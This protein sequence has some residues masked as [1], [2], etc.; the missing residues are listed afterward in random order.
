MKPRRKRKQKQSRNTQPKAIGAAAGNISK[1]SQ[2]LG[3]NLTYDLEVQRDDREI[4]AIISDAEYWGKLLKDTPVEKLDPVVLESLRRSYLHI[5][6]MV[7]GAIAE[8]DCQFLN[9]LAAAVQHDIA[10]QKHK[11]AAAVLQYCTL[12]GCGTDDHPCDPTV[13]EQYLAV[14]GITYD[15]AYDNQVP[16][17]LRKFCQKI[18]VVLLKSPVGRPPKTRNQ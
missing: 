8:A 5:G 3:Q 18:G 14:R 10:P 4:A 7:S 17:G 13:L 12:N 1:L 16:R 15:K 11:V 6:A 2:A 9:K